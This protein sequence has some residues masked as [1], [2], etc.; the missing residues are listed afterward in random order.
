MGWL[1][2][3]NNRKKA[4]SRVGLI[5]AY[6]YFLKFGNDHDMEAGLPKIWKVNGEKNI[7][8]LDENKD[9]VSSVHD[10]PKYK[11]KV[12]IFV[13]MAPSLNKSW[14]YLKNLSDRYVIVATNSSAKFLGEHGVYPHYV[15]LLDGKPGNWTL[16]LGE[17]FKE[18]IGIFGPAG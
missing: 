17:K 4:V 8:W 6:D 2:E 15:L 16:N 13:G 14:Q 11:D 5:P 18:V 1:G 10:I 3:L 7:P 9:R 12:I